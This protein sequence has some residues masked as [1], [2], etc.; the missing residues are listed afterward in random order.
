M[1]K[2]FCIISGI[3]MINKNK[4]KLLFLYDIEKTK[5]ELNHVS[6]SEF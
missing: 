4:N 1:F 2:K 6:I 5:S 3:I